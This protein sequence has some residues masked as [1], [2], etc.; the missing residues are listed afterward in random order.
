MA[1]QQAEF[2]RLLNQLAK[3]LG[4]SFITSVNG[5]TSNA[6]ILK[7][8][9]AVETGDINKIMRA[10]GM[11][12]GSWSKLTEQIRN[13]YLAGGEF[14]I[15]QE[16]PAKF[17]MVYD[18]N[19]K[20]AQRWL[21]LNSS[22]LV[23]GLNAGHQKAL[24]I[25]LKDGLKLG[26]S[27]RQIALDIT[28]RMGKAPVTGVYKR[29]GGIM[30]LNEPQASAVIKARGELQSIGRFKNNKKALNYFT[31][32][33]RIKKFDPIVRKAM[34]AGKALTNAQ[35]TRL[36]GRYSDNL[37]H[38]R[39]ANIGRTEAL[40][41]VN[42]ASH[43]AMNQVVGEGL[44]NKKAIKRI[45][46]HGGYT[47]HERKGHRD[48]TGQKVK[49]EDAFIN[50]YTNVA[51][52]YPGT[53]P[54][55]ETINCRCYVEHEVD[56]VAIEKAK[57][58]PL[59]GI[60]GPKPP[61]PPKPSKATLAARALAEKRARVKAARD[62]REAEKARILEAERQARLAAMAKS[63]KVP[64]PYNQTG[65]KANPQ[66]A[67][68]MMKKLPGSVVNVEKFEA[69]LARH[70][71]GSIFLNAKKH[72]V[73]ASERIQIEMYAGRAKDM[74]TARW[75]KL[76][77]SEADGWTNVRTNHVN[78]Y[79]YNP[80]SKLT[81]FAPQ[82]LVDL[83]KQDVRRV[84]DKQARPF[85]LGDRSKWMMRGDDSYDFLTWIHEMGHQVHFK[86]MLK[87]G[88]RRTGGT[89][90]DKIR[91]KFRYNKGSQVDPENMSLSAY[92]DQDV[93][94]FAAEHF[95]LWLL[96]YD[97]LLAARPKI[98]KYLDDMYAAAMEF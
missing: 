22:K 28:G 51:L 64:A 62:A 86:A 37:L 45:W 25:I 94:E 23:K 48:M 41:S 82:K 11:R 52:M 30:G 32:E 27:P 42:A 9:T 5:I 90:R 70:Q 10:A 12:A 84:L 76:S 50:P 98:A 8:V 40:A 79:I 29:L 69:F 43:N 53:G 57:G 26:R 13:S 60:K 46:H 49:F 77:P 17:G 15:A 73:R 66:A 87:G 34:K 36:T 97:T 93:Y 58:T 1:I 31:R 85:T 56:F 63:D 20:A 75:N 2:N 16:I 33:R 72:I 38:L 92:G 6:Q 89:I 81:N 44:A 39:G 67:L 59:P 35:V 21:L 19:N 83:L 14:A 78:T 88:T 24:Q 4:T 65:I 80:G 7:L 71:V 68:N 18:I 96:D 95:V 91:D 55:S 47:K 54:A 74:R 61:K 3:V